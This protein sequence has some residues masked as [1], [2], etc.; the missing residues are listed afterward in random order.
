MTAELSLCAALLGCIVVFK[1]RNPLQNY[2]KRILLRHD[3][4]TKTPF[5]LSS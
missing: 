2:W 3:P 5:Q 4:T 1:K